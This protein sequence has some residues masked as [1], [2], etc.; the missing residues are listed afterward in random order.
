MAVHDPRPLDP[1]PDEATAGDGPRPLATFGRYLL[2]RRLK[3]DELGEVY[4]AG[5]LGASAIESMVLLRLF[6]GAEIDGERF[7]HACR[8]RAEVGSALPAGP[9]ANLVDLGCEA[10]VAFVAH[11]LVLGRSL[12]DLL[13]QARD[14][15][16]PV[17]VAH[18]LHVMD[19][20]ALALQNAYQTRLRE[21]RIHHGFLIPDFVH[22]SGE[23][24]IRLAG[25]ESAGGLLGL[26]PTGP[27][28]TRLAGYLAPEVNAG[29]PPKGID[30][31]YSMAAIFAELLTGKPAP[32]LEAGATSGWLEGATLAAE[33]AP[34]PDGI[35]R[36]LSASLVA[37]DERIQTA[38]QWHRSLTEIVA[39]GARASTTFDLAFFVHTLFGDRLEQEADLV[40][41]EMRAEI[42]PP[43]S[44]EP[45]AAEPDPAPEPQA[46]ED[47]E[48]PEDPSSPEAAPAEAAE[49]RDGE[50]TIGETVDA[51]GEP[52]TPAPRATTGSRAQSAPAEPNG[53]KWLLAGAAALVLAGLG[54]AYFAFGRPGRSV[55]APAPLVVAAA[56]RFDEVASTAAAPEPGAVLTGIS[57]VAP[58]LSPEELESQV[59]SLVAERA[60]DLEANLKAQYD[61]RLIELR[62]QLEE[63]RKT[64][65]AAEP[66]GAAA[67]APSA[68]PAAAEGDSGAVS[69]PVARPPATTLADARIEPQPA[70]LASRP[71]AP[72]TGAQ[73]RPAVP[74]PDPTAREPQPAAAE[75]PVP[76]VAPEPPPV[77]A[78]AIVVNGPGVIAP[79]LLRQPNAVYPP[80]A[81]RLKRQATVRVRILVDEEG[82]PSEIEQLGKKVGLGF[83]TAALQAARTTRWSPP[84]KDGVPV[85]MWV[86][87]SIDFRQ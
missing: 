75:A 6:N 18:A 35:R 74:A 50:L 8:R 58:P 76:V 61:R 44:L 29:Q 71:A 21:Q 32:V 86:E 65:P 16:E 24:E 19:R 34:L 26:S 2:F 3:R 27:A 45:D 64:A 80:A 40:E 60:G 25:F 5:R 10:G 13:E 42:P 37:R 17:P 62:R 53:R 48:D 69:D 70:S 73:E 23:G 57:E 81:A 85:K 87:L 33:A 49:L 78:G 63:A 31:V 56:P 68:R 55:E 51:P 14:A 59:R 52:A 54:A 30:D 84:E 9:F 4:R 67:A 28:R 83:D 22:I 38:E 47:P 1:R 11:E 77:E 12:A 82:K 36:L 7:W 46:S 39:T 72:Q 15:A 20:I 43:A 66:A 41:A 79:T